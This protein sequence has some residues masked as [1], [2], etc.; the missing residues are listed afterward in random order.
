MSP[1]GGKEVVLK[2]ENFFSLFFLLFSPFLNSSLQC[3]LYASLS[4]FSFY[5]FDSFIYPFTF[6]LSS[7]GITHSP[8]WKEIGDSRYRGLNCKTL[9]E[10]LNHM[11]ISLICYFDGA[12]DGGSVGVTPKLNVL[13]SNICSNTY[14]CLT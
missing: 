7:H 9:E 4:V 1:H 14:S 6:S 13:H 5:F 8:T 2:Q 11:V 10:A 12:I 3:L